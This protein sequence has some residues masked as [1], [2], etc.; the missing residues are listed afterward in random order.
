M[1]QI[2][3]LILYEKI[4]NFQNNRI[5]VHTL[6]AIFLKLLVAENCFKRDKTA[7]SSGLSGATPSTCSHGWAVKER[8]IYD[9][10]LQICLIKQGE[11]NGKIKLT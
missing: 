4:E 10:N 1:Q 11:K 3:T 6:R 7:E 5:K 2:H 9:Q 8:I